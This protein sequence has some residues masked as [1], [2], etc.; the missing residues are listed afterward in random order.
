MISDVMPATV[1][2]VLFLVARVAIQR[3]AVGY[4]LAS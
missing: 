1:T 3:A 2:D 4:G